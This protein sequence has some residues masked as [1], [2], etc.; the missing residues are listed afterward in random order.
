MAESV[1]YCNVTSC[2]LLGQL[3]TFALLKLLTL[4]WGTLFIKMK[5][6]HLKFILDLQALY[7]SRTYCHK[8]CTRPPSCYMPREPNILVSV[9]WDP[10]MLTCSYW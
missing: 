7:L 8:T 1:V 2:F 5:S 4:R 3:G 9:R 10:K 6:Y